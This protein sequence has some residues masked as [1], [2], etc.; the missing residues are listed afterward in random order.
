MNYEATARSE[1]RNT[2]HENW[3]WPVCVCVCG[4]ARDPRAAPPGAW[5]MGNV[6]FEEVE[7]GTKRAHKWGVE[8]PMTHVVAHQPGLV[9]LE[10]GVGRWLVGVVGF[11][12]EL[13]QRPQAARGVL[14]QFEC[15][16]KTRGV[17]PGPRGLLPKA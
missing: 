14:L 15:L 10:G 5:G 11:G 2:K 9:C 4:T 12:A 1:T 7:M 3:P 17:A 8:R 6:A 13:L 16:R